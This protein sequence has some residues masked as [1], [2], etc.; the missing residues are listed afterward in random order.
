M[1]DFIEAWRV[2]AQEAN[3]S[4]FADAKKFTAFGA[5]FSD[6]LLYKEKDTD[7]LV[8][9]TGGWF[10]ANASKSSAVKL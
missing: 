8:E 3:K 5:E 9:N 6:T 4:A 7:M 10:Y 2:E 1:T